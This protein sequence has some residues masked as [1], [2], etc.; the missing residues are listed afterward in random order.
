MK[1]KII[2]LTILVFIAIP[3]IQRILHFTVKIVGILILKMDETGFNS[4]GK[5]A[6]LYSNQRNLE[7]FG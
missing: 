4:G 6:G 3:F 5:L 1:S 7:K 2:A